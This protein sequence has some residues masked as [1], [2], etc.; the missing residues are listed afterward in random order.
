[1]DIPFFKL[2][3]PGQREALRGYFRNRFTGDS[4]LYLNTELRLELGT[5]AT[6]FLPFTFGA[7]GFYDVG[8]VYYSEEASDKWHAGYGGGFYIF[9]LKESFTFN[10][11]LGFSEEETALFML[12]VGTTFR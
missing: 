11:S 8:R 9:P 7:K 10:F 4:R 5:V 2:P 3:S 1:G 6:G 12:S